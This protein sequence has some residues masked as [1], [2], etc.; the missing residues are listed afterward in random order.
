M[1]GSR[2]IAVIAEDPP[3]AL[4]D[5]IT[6]LPAGRHG[7][8]FGPCETNLM[9]KTWYK[10]NGTAVQLNVSLLI[11]AAEV[12]KTARSHLHSVDTLQVITH[13]A[14]EPVMLRIAGTYEDAEFHTKNVVLTVV[15]AQIDPEHNLEAATARRR[16]REQGSSRNLS[17]DQNATDLAQSL[18]EA[19][20]DDD[21]T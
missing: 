8:R 13:Q 5:A 15:I 18:L 11:K 19:L 1:S 3:Q 6:S 12:L 9:A 16:M 7:E 2:V 4:V 21:G 17:P 20:S 10:E 14:N